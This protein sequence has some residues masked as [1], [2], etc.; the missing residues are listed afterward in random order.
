[1][2][3]ARASRPPRYCKRQGRH[4]HSRVTLAFDFRRHP[5]HRRAQQ[6]IRDTNG[7]SGAKLGAARAALENSNWCAGHLR[8][9]LFRVAV[10]LVGQQPRLEREGAR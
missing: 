5:L 4:H 3:G 6:P 10:G 7:D 1:L 2:L 9:K 8:Q